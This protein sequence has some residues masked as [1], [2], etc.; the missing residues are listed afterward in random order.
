MS[1]EFV[2]IG[3]RIGIDLPGQI[4]EGNAYN[5]LNQV[6]LSRLLYN[7]YLFIVDNY[8]RCYA[9][10]FS[11]EFL[12]TAFTI[13]GL[14]LYLIGVYFLI[15]S[16]NKSLIALLLISPLVPLFELGPVHFRAAVIYVSQVLV[17]LYGLV[18]IFGMR[19]K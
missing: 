8:A 17:M 3:S 11:P 15:R 10:Y 2:C 14:V 18:K 16:K 19:R 13:F 1:F 9:S 4:W 6:I 7:K 5:P 12:T